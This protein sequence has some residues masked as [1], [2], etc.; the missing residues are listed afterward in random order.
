MVGYTAEV[1]PWDMSTRTRRVAGEGWKVEVDV[2]GKVKDID[3]G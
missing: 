1:C 2:L 3:I